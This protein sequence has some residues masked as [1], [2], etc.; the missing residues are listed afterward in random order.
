MI[1]DNIRLD[2]R[3]C[4]TLLR[5]RIAEKAPGRIQLLTGPRQVGKT[6]LLLQLAG[7]LKGRAIYATA[8]GPEASLPGFWERI[9]SSAEEIAHR[10]GDAVVLL[11][12]VQ[13]LPD[14]SRRLKGEWD[15]IHRLKT[16]LHV[17]VTGSS[18][19]RLGSASRESLAGRFERVTLSH[20]PAAAL[21]DILHVK[22]G[23]A[24]ET[25][26]LTGSYPGAHALRGDS[27]RFRAYVRDAIVEPAIGRDVLAL[28][29]VRRPALLRQIFGF[30]A[31]MPAQIVSLQ[32]LQGR[33]TDPGALDT[34]AHYL[35]L[36]EDAYLIAPLE[37]FSVR[38]LRR[39][40]APPKI[41]VLSNALLAGM[42]PLG[43]PDRSKDP[44]RFGAWVENA[45]LA[46]AWNSGQR[47]TYWREEPIEVD[48][49]IE[50]TWGAWAVEVKTGSFETHDLKGVLE[51][52]RRNPRFRPLVLHGP[53]GVAAARRAQ[54]A[55]MPW[56]RFLLSRPPQG[57]GRLDHQNLVVS[58]ETIGACH[59]RFGIS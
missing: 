7:S 6:T 11:D 55:S 3:G 29:P 14:W 42:D 22:A 38:P 9:W 48:G 53:E 52:C 36:L 57:E 49:V 37:K 5:Q 27:A 41:I 26:V 13:H 16:P 1:A 19:L 58:R 2:Y 59:G 31:S 35:H 17:I 18:A 10:R 33:L 43:P 51:F 54:V 50:G 25:Q 56:E 4:R 12:E 46:H 21:R 32:K 47:V 20:W 28:E 34:I 40:S 30:C 39:R 8:D 45:C 23:A 15:R 44:G 24:A